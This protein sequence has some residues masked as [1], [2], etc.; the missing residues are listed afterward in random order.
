[1]GDILSGVI[2]SFI[3][4]GYELELAAQLGLCLHSLA[5]DLAAKDGQT[6]LLATD[7]L[8]H[9]RQLVNI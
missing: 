7:L 9:I 4:Q 6:G 2:G 1:M 3:A 8:I 5:G